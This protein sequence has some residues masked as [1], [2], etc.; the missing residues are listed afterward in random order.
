[1][2]EEHTKVSQSVGIIISYMN[3]HQKDSTIES[4][5]QQPAGQDDVTCSQPSQCW[6]SG[7][8]N[9]ATKVTDVKDMRTVNRCSVA[10]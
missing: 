8:V 9:G 2:G 10:E 4:E 5:I 3:A 7:P 6:Y 1:M